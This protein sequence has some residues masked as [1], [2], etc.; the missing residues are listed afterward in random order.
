MVAERNCRVTLGLPRAL[1]LVDPKLLLSGLLALLVVLDDPYLAEES[2]KPATTPRVSTPIIPPEALSASRKMPMKMQ[3]EEIG[4]HASAGVQGR[5]GLEILT[6]SG[7]CNHHGIANQTKDQ[8]AAALT[9]S[10]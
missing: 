10:R 7:C 8:R 4:E 1:V 5:S 9:S 3:V 2:K 6:A